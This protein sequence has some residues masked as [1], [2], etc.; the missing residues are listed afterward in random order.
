[1]QSCYNITSNV[2]A[3]ETDTQH[4]IQ[5]LADISFRSASCQVL[6]HS[7]TDKRLSDDIL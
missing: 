5:F 7:G 2:F 4:S 1:M 3:C 6:H